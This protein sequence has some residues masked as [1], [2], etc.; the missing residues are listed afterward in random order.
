MANLFCLVPMSSLRASPFDLALDDLIVAV[1]TATNEIGTSDPSDANTGGAVVM[2]EP[3]APADLTRDDSGT[4]DL[5]LSVSFPVTDSHPDN[6]GSSVT[7]IALYWDEGNGD[8]VFTAL[9]GES[10]DSLLDTFTVTSGVTRSAQ[11]VFKHRAAN[12]FGW[13]DYSTAVTITAATK[14]DPMDTVVTTITSDSKVR[15]SF[16]APDNRGDTIASYQILILSSDL[17]TYLEDTTD[18]DGSDSTIMSNE[19]CEIPLATL[20]DGAFTG[21]SQGDLIVATVTATNAFG[22][23][24]VSAA[25]TAGALV[26]TVPHQHGSAPTRGASTYET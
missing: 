3:A 10:S 25:N 1:V 19:Y 26:E 7:S 12:I 20:Q 22:T 5:Q 14:P 8:G 11:Y 21:L 9:V 24:T 16:V 23:S 2:T 13:G 17:A 6:G 4:S 15:I 18:C